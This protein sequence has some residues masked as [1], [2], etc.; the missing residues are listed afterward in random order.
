MPIG[1]NHVATVAWAAFW[2]T[3]FGA[4]GGHP[5]SVPTT[6]DP[7][8]R[9]A[10]AA[11]DA[12][13]E[14]RPEAGPVPAAPTEPPAV[15]DTTTKPYDVVAYM[16]HPHDEALFAGGT[17]SQLGR[18]GRH[19]V[20]V[21]MSHGEG[22]RLLQVTP[23]GQFVERDDLPPAKIAETRDRE[24]ARA[25]KTMQ[26]ETSFLYPVEAH[27]DFGKV[28]ACSDAI[29]R[30]SKTLPGGIADVLRRLVTDIR[31]RRPRVIITHDPRDDSHWMEHGH[32]KGF[33]A[34]VEMAARMAAD[35]RVTVAGKEPHVVQE[36]LAIAPQGV[37]PDVSLTVGS[38]LR[39]KA[40]GEYPSQF[41]HDKAAEL[42]SRKVEDY[43]VRWRAKGAVVPPVGS[44][45]G[46][47]IAH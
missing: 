9:V 27:A 35:P 38:E 12:P 46:D 28:T 14:A 16:A 15:V 11:T 32:N 5:S 37:N 13:C 36:V 40:I 18:A 19:V 26:V 31:A 29:E 6:G 24:V 33:G 30:W 43:V 45:I 21:F 4:C 1:V 22:G 3:S 42:A 8:D 39:M 10:A 25:A 2:L 7:F 17:L 20:V 41:R 34:L 23:N 44:I 47:L